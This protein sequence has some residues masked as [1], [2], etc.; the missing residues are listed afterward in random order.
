[1]PTNRGCKV[2]KKKSA[3]YP[4]C[5]KNSFIYGNSRK[6]NWLEDNHRWI[7]DLG[8]WKKMFKK[9]IDIAL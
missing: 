6:I 3:S 8:K 1:M 7:D 9:N 5:T 4:L 2:K